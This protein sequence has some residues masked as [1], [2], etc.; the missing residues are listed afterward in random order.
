MSYPKYIPMP[1]VYRAWN[2]GYFINIVVAMY[3]GFLVYLLSIVSTCICTCIT[4]EG[5]RETEWADPQITWFSA[6]SIIPLNIRPWLG[7]FT[8]QRH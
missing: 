3:V 5:L 1:I 4:V 7:G 8:G 2:F 6:N